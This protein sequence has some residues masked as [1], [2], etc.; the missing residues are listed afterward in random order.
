MKST[1][2]AE[3]S[4]LVERDYPELSIKRQSELLEI[5]RTGLYYTPVN[6]EAKDIE[7]MHRIDEIYTRWPH[8]GYRRITA[9]LKDQ[10]YSINQKKVKRLMGRMGIAG[11]CP[12]PT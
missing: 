8:F 2:A 9:F 11:L 3:R 10:G 1:N 7:W 12:E 4:N 5:N 6:R